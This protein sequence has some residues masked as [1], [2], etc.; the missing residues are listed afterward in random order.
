MQREGVG[1]CQ[2][3]LAELGRGA[4]LAPLLRSARGPQRPLEPLAG[5]PRF[6][7]SV[8]LAAAGARGA[9][10]GLLPRCC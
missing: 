1:A 7:T 5:K 2:R 4:G 8:I 3:W 6:K 9:L 10:D